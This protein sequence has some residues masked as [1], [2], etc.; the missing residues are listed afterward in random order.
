MA[1]VSPWP[2]DQR[3]LAESWTCL[4]VKRSHNY[5]SLLIAYFTTLI[6][7]H[8]DTFCVPLC[9]IPR[10]DKGALLYLLLPILIVIVR[11]TA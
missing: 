5:Y 3:E 10:V 8:S 4:K 2:G 7:T 9:P 6:G 1:S 11:T